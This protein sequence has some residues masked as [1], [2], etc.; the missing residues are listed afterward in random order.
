MHPAASIIFFS[1]LS[2]LGYGL[3][4]WLGLGVMEPG[5][6]STLAAYALALAL[7]GAGLL[8]STL[9]LGNPQRAWRAFSQWRSSWLSRE[10]VL[11]V[12]GFPVIAAH[13]WLTFSSGETWPLLG[14][15]VAVL[16]AAT[17][18]CTA[19]I[20]ASL[21]SVQAWNTKLTPACYLAFAAAG[22]GLLVNLVVMWSRQPGLP[23]VV[24]I[25]LLLLAW[26]LKIVWW[27]RMDGE[28]L[29]S[30]T[31]SATGLGGIGRVKLFEPPHMTSNYLTREMGFQV[32]RK[33]A[34]KLRMIALM[35]GCVLP[36]LLLL[37]ALGL[38][39]AVATALAL[40]AVAAF[41]AGILTERWLF[42]AE[43]RH[44]VTSYYGR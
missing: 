36:I 4:A 44:A 10:G 32:A 11:A 25:V 2:G 20:Y 18:Y 3:A 9:H 39:G 21:R 22:G 30:T 27:R 29:L 33:H 16:C 13:G 15:V 19:M 42:F 43:A 12:L 41:Y 40:L 6:Y 8:S 28:A 38:L 34:R 26:G 14:S 37:I 17:V 7:I 35:L 24:Y 5:L 1:T 31:A 23:P